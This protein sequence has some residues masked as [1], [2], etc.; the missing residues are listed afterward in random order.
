VP[1]LILFHVEG[2]FKKF[3]GKVITQQGDLTKAYVEISISVNSIYTGNQDRDSNLHGDGFFSA[4]EYPHILFTST[5]IVITGEQSYK[6]QGDL[7]MRGVK[8]Q[9]N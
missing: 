5:S 9:L 1:H 8:T 6:M 7:T 3:S 4:D 2:K